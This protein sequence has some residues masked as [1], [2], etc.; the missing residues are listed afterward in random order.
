MIPAIPPIIDVPSIDLP[1]IQGF[2]W[3]WMEKADAVSYYAKMDVT[4]LNKLGLS[5]GQRVTDFAH[6]VHIN[7]I[8]V[9]RAFFIESAE[10]RQIVIER[11][12]FLSKYITRVAEALTVKSIR[13][14]DPKTK[15]LKD[16]ES[17][18]ELEDWWSEMDLDLMLR[19]AI[20]AG[21]GHQYLVYYPVADKLP[22]YYTRPN[23][24]IFS[25][26]I[27]VQN[28][29]DKYGHPI[30]FS[31]KTFAKGI[32]E[33]PLSISNCLF[34]DKNFTEDFQ[35]LLDYADIWDDLIDY[36][37]I[38]EAMKSFDQR[39]GNG[40]ML[41]AVPENTTPEEMTKT[42]QKIKNLR[43]EMGLVIRQNPDEPV[44]VDWM[45]TGVQS[46][47]IDHLNKFEDMF[48]LS[49]G[50]PKRWLFGDEA[51]AK[52]S[53]GEDHEQ[54]K[55]KLKTVFALWVPFIKRVLKFHGKIKDFKEVEILPNIELEMS[56]R[57][58]SEIENIKAQTI[59]LKTWLS[60][61]EQREEDGK[62]PLAEGELTAAQDMVQQTE[63]AFGHDMR[64]VWN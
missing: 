10:S 34:F 53:S 59:G 2:K 5:S 45:Q 4:Y 42:E 7:S 54:V 62:D 40:F 24:H 12:P 25:P 16:P 18:E 46:G 14:I 11:H 63:E 44:S 3:V 48:I 9:K 33:F 13:I 47:F 20:E 1:T 29:W 6:Y 60:L 56:E 50:F 17:I 28:K 57:E 22:K 43:T 36:I 64:V 8:I 19:K 23:W 32:N 58:R 30:V 37:F 31:I 21:R 15:D 51:G 26:L 52:M 41:V 61:D 55:K 39:L 38:K 49:M 27:A 35:G